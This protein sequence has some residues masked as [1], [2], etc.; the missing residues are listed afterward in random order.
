MAR[1]KQTAS[2]SIRG[3]SPREQLKR[4]KRPGTRALQEIRKYQGGSAVNGEDRKISR[5]QKHATKLLLRKAPF[6]RLVR[7]IADSVL[8]DDRTGLE[9]YGQ[10]TRF[11]KE[12]MEVLQ[13]AAEDYL[14]KLFED[15]NLCAIHAKRQTIMPQDIQLTR[16][17]RGERG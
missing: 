11:T 14:V 6:Q 16:R 4:R 15:T 5:I 13:H 3:K 12:A 1:T 9:L 2:K 10:D 7:E 8:K 17:I